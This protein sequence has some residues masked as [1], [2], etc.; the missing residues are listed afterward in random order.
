LV[1]CFS[2]ARESGEMPPE[3]DPVV[4]TRWVLVTLFGFLVADPIALEPT[5]GEARSFL[6]VFMA[7]LRNS[8]G[9][10]A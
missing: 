6:H 4:L 1:K 5:R 2:V 10:L 7:G 9:T 8:R 3:H